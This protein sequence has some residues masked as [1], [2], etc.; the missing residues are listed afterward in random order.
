MNTYLTQVNAEIKIFK[1]LKIFYFFKNFQNFINFNF[2]NNLGGDKYSF[3][4]V[5]FFQK[6]LYNTNYI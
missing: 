6:Y 5:L 2:C 1:I 4:P 3:I